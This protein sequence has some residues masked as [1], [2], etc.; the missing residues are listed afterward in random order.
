MKS[1]PVLICLL[2]AVLSS[3]IAH[4]GINDGMA[5]WLAQDATFTGVR[6]V[7]FHPVVNNTGK[8]FDFDAAAAATQTLRD[9]LTQAGMVLISPGDSVPQRVVIRSSLEYYKPGS[10]GGRWVGFGG[11]SAVC[12]LRTLLLDGH[13]DRLL[14]DFTAAYQVQVGGLFTIGAE[15]KV[16]NAAAELLADRILKLVGLEEA[17]NEID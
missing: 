9:R 7:E 6:Q 8:R 14:G 2:L 11:G 4:A 12:I 15:K 17:N 10:V 5:E 13:S 1:K 3:G 16:P